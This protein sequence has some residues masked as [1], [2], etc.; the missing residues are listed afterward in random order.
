MRP[1]KK[2]YNGRVEDKKK[3]KNKVDELT[4][5]TGHKW[6][7]VGGFVSMPHIVID[8]T[9]KSQSI[10]LNRGVTAKLFVDTVT[11]EMKVFWAQEF[12]EKK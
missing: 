9:N 2:R 8:P 11:N 1:F 10:D 6:E 12:M 7:E 5:S 4:K 3:I